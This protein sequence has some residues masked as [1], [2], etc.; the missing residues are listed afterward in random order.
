V[1]NRSNVN[2]TAKVSPYKGI[3]HNAA[4]AA[5]AVTA[6]GSIA[7]SNH[8]PSGFSSSTVGRCASSALVSIWS[9]VSPSG[10]IHLAVSER[11]V[12]CQSSLPTTLLLLMMTLSLGRRR[13]CHEYS[14]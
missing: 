3:A 8:S 11:D 10:V 13:R 7:V 2:E 9:V 6:S 12:I 4:A 1:R 5:A 14:A